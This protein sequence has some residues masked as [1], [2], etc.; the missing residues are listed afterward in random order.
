MLLL[1]YVGYLMLA[2][3]IPSRL[4]EVSSPFAALASLRDATYPPCSA[5]YHY[6]LTNP[7]TSPRLAELPKTQASACS[8][9]QPS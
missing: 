3:S 7:L 2:K 4:P 1:I 9:F 6:H 5:L 8:G